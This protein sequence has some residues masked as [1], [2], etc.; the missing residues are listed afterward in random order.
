[1]ITKSIRFAV[2]IVASAF[3]M[4][5]SMANSTMAQQ[6]SDMIA[7][8]HVN[9]AF[10][11]ALS[12]HNIEVLV[13]LWSFR[14]PIRYIGPHDEVIHVGLDAAV[15]HWK[16]RFA[17]FPEFKV[18]SEPNYIRINSDTALVSNVEKAHWKNKAGETQTE[19]R[20]GTNIFAR[21]RG[22][23]LMVYRHASVVPQETPLGH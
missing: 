16:H 8:S 5:I 2:G 22:E 19:I 14:T 10:Y 18:E 3:V 12:A 9:E 6:A 11:N 15:N 4:L 20:F 21:E 23:W 17:A 13:L 7:V 1:M